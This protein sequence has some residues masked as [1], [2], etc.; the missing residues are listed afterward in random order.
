MWLARGTDYGT[1]VAWRPLNARPCR[2][3][4]LLDILKTKQ[5]PA[6]FF[7]IGVQLDGENKDRREVIARC[8]CRTVVACCG[9]LRGVAKLRTGTCGLA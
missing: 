7:V 3:E 2:T 6:A 8:G 9:P 4:R 5:A 1:A